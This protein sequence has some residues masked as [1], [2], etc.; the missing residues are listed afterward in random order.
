MLELHVEL[1]VKHDQLILV[2]TPHLEDKYKGTRMIVDMLRNAD[3]ALYAAKAA[4]R[5]ASEGTVTSYI[6]AGGRIGVLLAEQVDERMADYRWL[7]EELRVSFFAQELRTPVVQP[8]AL[9][10][11]S[12]PTR[13]PPRRK[14]SA[15]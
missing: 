12:A 8:A 1:A 15:P 10:E 2:H 9:W 3:L 6:H 7:L 13:L 5:V 14:S 11:P 4:G